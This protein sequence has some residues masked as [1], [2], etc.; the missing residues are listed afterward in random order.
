MDEKVAYMTTVA[1]VLDAWHEYGD[2]RRRFSREVEE[3]TAELWPTP[4]PMPSGEEPHQPV[5]I[6]EH[7][8]AFAQGARRLVGFSWRYALD[9][10]A[11]WK[12]GESADGLAITP[13]VSTKLGKAISKRMQT[14]AAVRGVKLPGMP[15][16]DMSR[17]PSIYS[18]SAEEHAGAIYV[19]WSVA[20]KEPIDFDVWTPIKLS[21]YHAAREADT[22]A[23]MV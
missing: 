9:I 19:T 10:P 17:L 7:G 15:S 11:G 20:P 5:A 12:K 13:K 21:E 16:V 18:H 14:V 1:A 8:G 2:E 3:V 23:E 22:E 6:I 4:V